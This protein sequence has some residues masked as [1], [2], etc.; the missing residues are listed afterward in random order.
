MIYDKILTVYSLA[1]SPSPLTRKLGGG[2]Q[3]YYAEKEVYGSR[4]FVAHQAGE[5]INMMV[6]LPRNEADARITCNNY[7]IPED[8]NVYRIVQAQYGVD[9]DGLDITTLSLKWEDG[10]YDILGI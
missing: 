2:V 9:D 5:T 7:I 3:Y 8:G 6:E 1:P 10:K 4:Y